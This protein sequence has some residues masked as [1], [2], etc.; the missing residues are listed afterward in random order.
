MLFLKVQPWLFLFSPRLLWS[1]LVLVSLSLAPSVDSSAQDKRMLVL[2]APV[3]T[4][5]SSAL[6]GWARLFPLVT[7]LLLLLLIL[8]PGSSV[9]K[10]CSPFASHLS[11]DV[12]LALPWGDGLLFIYFCV[13]ERWMLENSL[14]RVAVEKKCLFLFSLCRVTSGRPRWRRVQS[15]V[16][17]F[18]NSPWC[19]LAFDEMVLKGP[20]HLHIPHFYPLTHR[21]WKTKR[22]GS[23]V[24]KWQCWQ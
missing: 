24:M 16:F 14:L 17:H 13:S 22:A 4:L 11:D 2:V 6:K 23:R 15:G 19:L 21:V 7:L 1:R 12:G 10:S 20:V 5:L 18:L 9:R 8:Y 3:A